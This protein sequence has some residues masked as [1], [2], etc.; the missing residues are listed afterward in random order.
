M[1]RAALF[2]L[3]ATLAGT[4]AGAATN[5]LFILDASNSMWGQVNGVPK[6]ETAKNTLARLVGDLPE[7]TRVGLMV[8]GHRQKSDCGDI[9]LVAPVATA[10]AQAVVAK[11]DQLTPTGKTPIAASLEASAAAFDGLDGPKSVVLIS[12]G[13][14]TC[15]GDPCSAAEALVRSGIGVRVHVVGFDLTPEER[16]ELECISEKGGGRYFAANSVEGFVAAVSEAVEVA[17][18]AP[19]PEPVAEPEPEPAKLA[20]ATPP[21]PAREELWVE[22]FEGEDLTPP[23]QMIN[24][25]PDAYL[26]EDGTLLILASKPNPYSNDESENLLIRDEKLPRGD[27]DIS[28]KFTAEMKTGAD[29]VG[30]GLRKDGQNY[31][32]AGLYNTWREGFNCGNVGVGI[33]KRLKGEMTK[34]E[35]AVSEGCDPSAH[36]G[37]VST[38]AEKGATLTLSKRGRSYSASVMFEGVTDDSGKPVVW[39]T[40]PLTTLRV[41]GPLTIGVNKW[42]A[43]APG[44]VLVL[45]DSIRMEKVTGEE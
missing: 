23:W 29:F 27:W 41:P 40:P 42:D 8:Y 35:V 12:D 11:L 13:V 44:E 5:I 18:S 31:M 10:G 16:A 24:P 45:I 37:V 17:R 25:N 3:A 6:I 1:L 7:D 14:E 21:A 38:V 34:F 4:P 26:V 9:E 33:Y 36:R 28:M 43:D 39:R 32:L 2:A 15:N 19:E 22:E 30:L 20:Q